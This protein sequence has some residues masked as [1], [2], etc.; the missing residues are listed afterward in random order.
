LLGLVLLVLV[1]CGMPT[2]VP[3]NKALALT[4]LP[5]STT[6]LSPT[7]VPSAT[8]TMIPTATL[9]PASAA[10]TSPAELVATPWPELAALEYG[11]EL[12]GRV[13][14]ERLMADVRWLADDARRGRLT[15]SLAEDEVGAWLV[16]RFRSLGLGPLAAAELEDY[17]LSFT[18][19]AVTIYGRA[20][21]GETTQA[22]NI[23]AML[24]GTVQPDSYVYIGAHYDHLGIS[25]NGQVFNGAD[26]DATGVAAVLEAARVLSSAGMRPQETVVFV[27]FTG[28]EIGTLGSKALCHCLTSFG[29][30]GRSM[31][32]NME[33]LGAR[34]GAGTYLDVWDEDVSSTAPLVEAVLLAGQELDIPVE[35]R[36]RD[37][38]SDALRLVACG[39]PAVSV[40]VAW[41]YENHPHYHQP[42]D[43]PQWIDEDG[44]RNAVRVAV[45]AL[46]LLA[47]DGQ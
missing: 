31:L 40:D 8:P 12:A 45:A 11:A 34:E 19:P 15:G 14:V 29:L 2:P 33:V 18:L 26:D 4:S 27:A 10:A 38:G 25:P 9:P 17:Y 36:G 30:T 46:W 6:K 28:E 41:S 7:P 16:E 37:P 13:S 24:P 20:A 44:F 21:E 39:I 47:N 23:I 22:E 3:T 42:S 35:R 32:L 43:D 5:A 1:C